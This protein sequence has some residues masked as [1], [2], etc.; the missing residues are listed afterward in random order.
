MNEECANA[1]ISGNEGTC[2]VVQWLRLYDPNAGSLGS[3][4]GQGTRSRMPQLRPGV[5]K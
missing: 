1:L 2:P 4:S 3:I 5:A